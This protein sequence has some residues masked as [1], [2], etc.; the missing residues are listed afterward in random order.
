MT[1]SERIG[2]LDVARIRRDFPILDRKVYGQ[3]LVYF[4]NAATSQKPR[5]VIEALTHYYETSNANIHR[6]VHLLGEEATAEYEGVREKVSR[7]INAPSPECI[8][9]TRNTSESINLVAYAWGRANVSA[10]DEI[11][12]TVM[13]HHSNFVPWQQLAQETGAKLVVIGVKEDQTLDLDDGLSSYLSERTKIVAITHANNTVGTINPVKELAAE[14]HRAGAL[15]LVDAAQSVP[16]MPV[17][18]QDLDC[19]FLAFSAHKML[20]PTGVGVLYARRELLAEMPPFLTGG[21][22]I[23]KVTIDETT[24]NGI[25]AKFEAGTPNI[26]DVVA[27]GA[28]IDY[29][30]DLGMQNVREHEKEITEYALR[31]LKQLE[32]IT[33][34]GPEDIDVHGGVIS[35]NYPGVHPHDVGTIVDRQGVAIRSGHGCNQPLM[36]SLDI[37]GVAR[38]S[39]Y[40]YNTAA[41]VDVFIDALGD[42]GDRF[43]G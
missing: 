1:T 6:A 7:F 31:R 20:G 34:Y 36:R 29:L 5:Q 25:P 33:I 11:V 9:F 8:V 3:P 23:S 19:D 26:A 15:V 38:A 43:N 17:D 13:E 28:A 40:V 27:F 4:D 35:F 22:M 10:G 42:V 18:V 16:H 32:S 39:F 30:S 41:E 21:E 37:S 12:V 24:W 14:A 2:A